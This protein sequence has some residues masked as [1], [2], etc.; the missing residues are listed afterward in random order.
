MQAGHFGFRI[1]EVPARTRYFDDA[2]SIASG[3]RRVYGL[4]TLWAA[5]RLVLCTGAESVR[6]RQ[7]RAVTD[8]RRAGHDA[9][10]AGSTRPGSAT[11]PPTRSA[12]PCCRP[13]PGARPR[14]RGR[15]LLRRAGAARDRRRRPRPGARS[16]ARSARRSSP[17]CARC[18]SPDASFAVG[19]GRAVDRARARPR[20]RARRGR[21]RARA[22]RRGRVRHPEP[23]HLRAP[24]RDHRPLPLRRVR[25]R[26]AARRSAP[27]CFDAVAM[28][29]LFGSDRAIASWSTSEQRRLDRLLRGTRCACAGWC[30]G[31]LRQ[32]LYDR[33]LTRAR[34]DDDPAR[35]RDQAGGLRAAR[36][37]ARG[38]P[39]RGRGVPGGLTARPRSS[40]T[41]ARVIPAQTASMGAT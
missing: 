35:R 3:R 40:A 11:S 28:H 30:R 29:G 34:R 7:V 22:G 26:A 21:P 25:P 37:G 12:R 41:N 9:E 27:R 10:P 16:P 20:A 38:L 1:A 23:A 17:T 19:A 13:G 36:H 4:K 5:A 6:S 14:L 33:L 31:G 2:S 32:R 24:R 39:R 15:A 8:H 18:R